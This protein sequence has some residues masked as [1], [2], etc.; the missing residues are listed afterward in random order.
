MMI[1]KKK[2]RCIED[3][4]M[5]RAKIVYCVVEAL[6]CHVK[7]SKLTTCLLVETRDHENYLIECSKR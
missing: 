1:V 5:Q 6:R 4:I 2:I 3:L 7:K